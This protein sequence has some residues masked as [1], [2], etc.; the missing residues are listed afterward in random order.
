[1][2]VCFGGEEGGTGPTDWRSERA[3]NKKIE[4]GQDPA[5]DIA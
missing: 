2:G 3:R 5:P 1:M 4:Q